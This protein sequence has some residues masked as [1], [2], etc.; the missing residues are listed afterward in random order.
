M[1]PAIR[2][3]GLARDLHV[4]AANSTS[5]NP[6]NSASVH[7]SIVPP[8]TTKPHIKVVSMRREHA[9]ALAAMQLRAY[10]TLHPQELFSAAHYRRHLEVFPEGQFVA[11][12]TDNGDMPV[13][14]TS[15]LRYH[16]D[17]E[18]PQHKFIEIIG[19]GWLN[20]HQPDAPW[21]YGCDMS[22]DPAYQGLGI[23]SLLY[24]ARM[25]Y[26]KR[27]NLRGQIA[28]GM[29]PGYHNYRATFTVDEYAAR[30]NTGEI[31]DPTLSKQLKSGFR[32]VQVIRDYLHDERS[33][34]SGALIVW[35]NPYYFPLDEHI[36]HVGS[37]R[38][39]ET[40]R[41]MEVPVRRYP[42]SEI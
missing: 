28:V 36:P 4:H 26:V 29:M 11:L 12:D 32:F 9:E 2:E 39:R 3:Q 33:G 22:V 17:F 21:L 5:T 42:H 19:Y 18:R 41:K 35:D 14:A 25:D 15:S 34:N 13:G 31:F 10:P 23:A 1:T 6:V 16:F 24:K 30:V 7:L 40:R 8:A 27:T 38:V 20:R 37:R